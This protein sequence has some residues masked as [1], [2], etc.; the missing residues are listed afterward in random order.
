VDFGV[1]GLAGGDRAGARAWLVTDF[2][3]AVGDRRVRLSARAGHLLGDSVPQLEFRAGG[4]HTV[5]GY[6][7]GVR[8]GRGVWAAQ[9]EIEIY[10]NEWVAPMLLVDVGNVIGNGAGSPLVGAGVGL[11]VGNGWLRIDLVKGLNPGAV[12]RADLGVQIPVW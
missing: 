2:R 6:E 5:R 9:G 4:R 7:Y 10:P 12:V 1:D 8:R 3:F 11:S